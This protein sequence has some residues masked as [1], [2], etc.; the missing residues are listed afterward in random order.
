MAPE[1]RTGTAPETAS[2]AAPAFTPEWAERV[3]A[4]VDRGAGEELRAAKLPTYWNWIGAVREG[5]SSSWALGVRDLPGR[6]TTYLRLGWRDGV[7]A[8]AAIIGPDDPLEATYV[9]AA[10]T[11]TWRDLLAGEDPGRIV[12]YRRLRLEEGNVL[13]FFRGI[14]FFV[15]AV[16][17]IGRVPALLPGQAPQPE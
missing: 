7:C 12:M 15:E 13:A 17:M 10:D 9:L 5:Y 2:G 14:Y 3:R 4:A 16:A 1:T 11:G 8:D 6:G